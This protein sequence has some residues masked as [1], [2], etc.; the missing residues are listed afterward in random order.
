MKGCSRLFSGGLVVG[1]EVASNSVVN[2][3]YLLPLG[4]S[5]LR[6]KTAEQ[7]AYR[8]HT[9]HDA[10]GPQPSALPTPLACQIKRS[11]SSAIS[12]IHDVSGTAHVTGALHT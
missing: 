11:G 10:T 8:E 2:F 4:S 3:M 7:R 9:I 1:S 12:A 6:K 5:L